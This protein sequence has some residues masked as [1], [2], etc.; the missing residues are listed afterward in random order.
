MYMVFL[1]LEP[2]WGKENKFRFPYPR[3]CFAQFIVKENHSLLIV[4]L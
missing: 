3:V 4:K 2:W 1:G